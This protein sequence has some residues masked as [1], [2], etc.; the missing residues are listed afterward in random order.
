MNTKQKL[1]FQ[2]S[3]AKLTMS[4]DF[5]GLIAQLVRVFEQNAVIVG[6][7]QTQ[8]DFPQQLAISLQW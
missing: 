3:S 4:A 7:N 5:H 1:K 8:T 2:S 6:T